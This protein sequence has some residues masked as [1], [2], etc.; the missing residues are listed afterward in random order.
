[1]TFRVFDPTLRTDPVRP[2]RVCATATS[3]SRRRTPHLV[4]PLPERVRLVDAPGELRGLELV[5]L[6]WTTEGVEVQLSYSPPTP[7]ATR[8]PRSSEHDPQARSTPADPR[9]ERLPNRH[10]PTPG[11]LQADQPANPESPASRNAGSLVLEPRT[12][13]RPPRGEAAQLV[14]M[15]STEQGAWWETLLGTEPSR[16][17][18]APVIPLLPMTIRSASR[19]SATSRIASAGSPWRA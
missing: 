17:R 19:S 9:T 4:D 13:A 7:T 10:A 11:R 14:L 6:G 2:S 1:M 8:S 15:I 18:L 16:K 5:V 3:K 12:A